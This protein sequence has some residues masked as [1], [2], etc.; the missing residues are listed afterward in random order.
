MDPA[1]IMLIISQAW[2]MISELVTMGLAIA[3]QVQAAQAA[4]AA[5]P[6]PQTAALVDVA[7]SIQTAHAQ[8]LATAAKAVNAVMAAAPK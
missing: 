1:T 4:H 2:P 7:T 8:V 3:Q 6:T 5:A